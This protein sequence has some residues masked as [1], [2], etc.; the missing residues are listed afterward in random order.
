MC[1]FV[2]KKEEEKNKRLGEKPGEGD[3]KKK[4]TEKLSQEEEWKEKPWFCG[5][6]AH[7]G[8]GQ[9]L[10]IDCQYN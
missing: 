7:T 9:L 8:I 10:V 1:M 5:E 3:E 2:V 4:Y 6:A